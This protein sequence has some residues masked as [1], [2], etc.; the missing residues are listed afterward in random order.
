VLTDLAGLPEQAVDMTTIVLIGN[1]I[2]RRFERFLITPRGYR[3]GGS[4]G[5]TAGGP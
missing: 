4:A 1:S 5:A 2:T 3:A